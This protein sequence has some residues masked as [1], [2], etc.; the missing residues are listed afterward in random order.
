MIYA[1]SLSAPHP[2]L[3]ALIMASLKSIDHQGKMSRYPQVRRTQPSLET[4]PSMSP[5]LRWLLSSADT[6]LDMNHQHKHKLDTHPAI[7]QI[8]SIKIIRDGGGRPKGFGFIEFAALDGLKDALA[9]RGQN[10]AGRT[11]RVNVAEP[12][13]PVLV[14]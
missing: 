6:R 3:F 10:F 11:V 7:S 8:K 14:S 13:E 9:R 4:C 12:R 5:S 2:A 1:V